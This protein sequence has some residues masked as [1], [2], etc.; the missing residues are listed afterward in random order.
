MSLGYAEKLSYIEDVGNVG[1]T[2]IFD[3][4]RILQEKIERLTMM[5]R[6]SKHL[7]V[8][9]GAGI[10]TSCGIPD[11]RGPTGIWTLQRGGNAL[12]EASLPFHRAMP[13]M[14]HMALVELE[15]AGILKFVISQNIDGLHL[16]SG[17]PREKLSELHGNSFMERCSCCG[18]EYFRDFE[19]E[20]VGLKETSRRCSNADCDVK[21]KDTV[22]DWEVDALPFEE[23]N[24]AEA[25]CEKADVVLCL[26]TS[27]QITPAC[28]LPLKCLRGGGKVVIVNLQKTP[29]DKKASLVIHGFVDKV[30]GG[31]M[32]LLNLRIRPFVR[33]DLLQTIFT[34]ALS[35]DER[36][37]N[38]TLRLA[39][40]HDK[41]AVL[42]FI[43]SVEVSF[44]GNHTMK[45]AVLDKH[46]FNL[47]RRTVL[48]AEPFDVILKV[49]LSEG[50]G[51]AYTRIK[52]P[53]DF[54]ASA[55]SM[56]R[57]KDHV[58]RKLKS[59]AVKGSYCGQN[60]VIERSVIMM[61][62]KTEMT[63]RA[64]VTNIRWY[65]EKMVKTAGA[66]SLTTNAYAPPL[67]RR[68]QGKNENGTPRK[69]LKGLI[70]HQT[71]KLDME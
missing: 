56:K 48:T 70:R 61:G 69:H 15:R 30:I 27:L 18:M 45:E 39:S 37:V 13:S 44:L 16:R 51:C 53:I 20:S 54:H 14:T 3:P 25:H 6:K 50:C 26:G 52:I 2:E 29:K 68:I 32:E 12:P 59:K 9:T 5:I 46:P 55:D 35:S 58:L 57:D 33:V 49:N 63:V 17:I 19:V 43:K 23:M 10:S 41:R 67:K 28:N 34:Q 42:P 8:F 38:W 47:K 1:M 65:D 60:S 31:I 7:V 4:P 11:F 64:I 40:V 71:V 62:P 22:L 21:L 66:G 24:P 36:Y